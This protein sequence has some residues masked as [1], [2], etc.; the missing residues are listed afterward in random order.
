MAIIE[1]P[2]KYG[3]RNLLKE[4]PELL[5]AIISVLPDNLEVNMITEI[6]SANG[7]KVFP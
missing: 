6:K 5:I 7:I 3:L 1:A 4:I 2:I